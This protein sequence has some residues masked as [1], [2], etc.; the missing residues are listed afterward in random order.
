MAK[1]KKTD[2]IILHCAATKP[3]M[4]IDI[5]T[6]DEWHRKRGFFS[7]G[8]HFVITRSGKLQEGRQLHDIGANAKGFNHRSIGICLVGG[9]T[10]WELK[11]V[12]TEVPTAG[13]W[14]QIAHGNP[15]AGNGFYV[16][17]DC[18]SFAWSG[19][20]VFIA[21]DGGV[22][23]SFRTFWTTKNLG[24][25]VTTL[26]TV[27]TNNDGWIAGGAQDNG[28]PLVSFGDN[29]VAPP[30]RRFLLRNNEKHSFLYD[31]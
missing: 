13:S 30:I 19:N 17:A 14:T 26:F 22:F 10:L 15:D 16:H 18:H 27:A 31:K 2:L 3:S 4:D 12:P 25:N 28:S 8:Y 11:I 6:I 24:Y 21:N 29:R 9:V 7:C 20:T 1:R 5:S 23:A